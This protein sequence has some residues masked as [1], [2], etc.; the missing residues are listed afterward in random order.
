[1]ASVLARNTFYLTI[2]SVGQKAIAFVYFALVA[3]FFGQEGTGVYFLA[4]AIIT[5]IAVF[6]DIG[7]TSVAIREVAK[8]KVKVEEWTQLILGVKCVTIPLTILF[9]LLLPVL[10]PGM[11]AEL[12]VLARIGLIVLIADSLSLTFF[13]LLRGLGDLRYESLG[14]FIGQTMTAIV[15]GMFLLTGAATLPLLVIALAVG[16]SWNLAFSAGMLGRR[17]GFH[18]FIP[19]WKRGLQPLKPAFAFFLAA[20]FV[21][22]YSYVDSFILNQLMGE[23]A[24][25]VYAVAYKLTYA[26]QF[27]PLAFVAALYPA[28]SEAAG[29]QD[30]LKKQLTSAFWYLALIGVPIVFGIWAI[31]PD[32]ITLVYSDAF[33]DSVLPLQVLIFVLL[34]IFLDFP[35]GSLL[36]SNDRQ[37]TKTVIGAA[38]M[39]LNIVFN[40]VL[41][42]IFGITGASIAAL[43]SFA[44]M[45]IVD[46]VVMQKTTTFSVGQLLKTIGSIVL[47]G[48]TMG[49]SVYLLAPFVPVLLRIIIGCVVY[50]VMLFVFGAIRK[51][52][53]NQL[54]LL[55]R[56]KL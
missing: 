48:L 46:W 20:V 32:L 28:M 31:A 44:F 33:L 40:L 9:V 55:I 43:G 22:V 2:A 8:Q 6:D 16:S 15:G 35:I 26:F 3:R 13:G 53:M 1:M 21:K 52:E 24:V 34:F 51:N 4:L 49:L 5:I 23:A 42:P 17:I 18:A 10:F 11:S 56:K 54:R 25:G 27:L 47:A 50:P 39:V 29:N 14:I 38:T 36:N 19:S 41:I 30:Q 37:M 12:F 45:L 7:L